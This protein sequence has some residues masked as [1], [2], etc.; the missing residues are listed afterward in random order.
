MSAIG[1]DQPAKGDSLAELVLEAGEVGLA[2]RVEHASPPEPLQYWGGRITGMIFQVKKYFT[3]GSLF[4]ELQP[5]PL[6][7]G[8]GHELGC[9]CD[10]PLQQGEGRIILVAPGE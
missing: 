7:F 5:P 8:G 3:I 6:L 2:R 10:A 1:N 4:G 9:I